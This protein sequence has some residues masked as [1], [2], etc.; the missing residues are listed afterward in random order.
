V[1]RHNLDP[2]LRLF[3]FPDPNLTNDRRASTT[4]PLQQLFVLNSEFISRQSRMLAAR[5]TALDTDDV[6][7]VHRAFRSAYGRLP[8]DREV[9]ISL[10]FLKEA[11]VSGWEKFAQVLLSANEF[12][13]VD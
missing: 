7:R 9:E 11:G 1:S 6:A 12:A 5:V 3:D 10:R 13:Y 2:L 8:H 4:V